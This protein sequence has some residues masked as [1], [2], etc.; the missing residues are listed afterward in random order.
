[1]IGLNIWLKYIVLDCAYSYPEESEGL[2]GDTCLMLEKTQK[3][4][5]PNEPQDQA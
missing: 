3:D 4:V 1:M 5:T 2:D